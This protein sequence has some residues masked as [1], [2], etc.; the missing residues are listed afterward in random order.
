MSSDK[1]SAR[2]VE[3]A[4]GVRVFSK[5]IS[6]P[7]S[8]HF[9]GLRRPRITPRVVGAGH[10]ISA[11]RHGT[12]AES[13]T[14]VIFGAA[15]SPRAPRRPSTTAMGIFFAL[16]MENGH[17]VL[18]LLGLAT[19]VA[20]VVVGVFR[21]LV[22]V[23]AF[24]VKVGRVVL[25][26]IVV[27]KLDPRLAQLSSAISTAAYVSGFLPTPS[28]HSILI[29]IILGC[30]ILI[31]L[32]LNLS[33]ATYPETVSRLDVAPFGWAGQHSARRSNARHWT[34]AP[35]LGLSARFL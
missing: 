16:G 33:T 22:A 24:N 7:G 32:R 23:D 11:G 25:P 6:A 31:L 9:P 19:V 29:L 20:T 4:P 17:N 13:F 35:T 14:L 15:R 8:A 28:R 2:R 12:L 26:V 3:A 27:D 34:F 1:Q 30:F 10:A 5:A 21:C 18:G